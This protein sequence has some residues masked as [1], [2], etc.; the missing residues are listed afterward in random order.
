MTDQPPPM[1]V[2]YRDENDKDRAARATNPPADLR[3]VEQLDLVVEMPRGSK[4][5]PGVMRDGRG[6]PG[7]WRP[8]ESGR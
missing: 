2:I 1:W 6:K 4:T 3:E 7:T 8:K 5:F